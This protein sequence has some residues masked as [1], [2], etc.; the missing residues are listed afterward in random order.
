MRIHSLLSS[1]CQVCPNSISGMGIFAG[2]ELAP[3][4]LV[5]VWGGAV[6]TAEECSR[7]AATLP[8]F[9][10]HTIG[11]CEGYFLG[12][13]HLFEYDDAELFNHSCEPNVGVRGQ[14]LL[15]ARRGIQRGEELTFD[16]ETIDTNPGGFACRCGSAKCRQVIDGRAWRESWFQEAHA[17]YLSFFIEELI[18]RSHSSPSQHSGGSR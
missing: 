15:V 8:Q 1:K 16:Y 17:G 7:L 2:D 3:G 5:A 6:Y 11:V 13:N 9:A 18:A 10:T 14:I 4:E 12:S